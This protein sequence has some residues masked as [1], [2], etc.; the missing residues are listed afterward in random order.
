MLII[1]VALLSCVKSL[2]PV[3]AN[4]N[5]DVE[6]SVLSVLYLQTECCVMAD[7]STW[8]VTIAYLIIQP[9]NHH[10][11]NLLAEWLYKMTSHIFHS[12][13]RSKQ[14][15]IQPLNCRLLSFTWPYILF[16]GVTHVVI[17]ACNYPLSAYIG[18]QTCIY[19]SHNVLHTWIGCSVNSEL[20]TIYVV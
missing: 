7:N 16:H 6:L 11:H 10:H 12:H 1:S 2:I 13:T 5:K 4:L 3:N 19:V 17:V 9:I 15:V 20:R 14:E 8:N 18:T